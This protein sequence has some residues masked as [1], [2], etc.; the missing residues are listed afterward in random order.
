MAVQASYN[1]VSVHADD[2]DVSARFYTELFDLTDLPAPD[3]GAPTR[4]LRVG[5][6]Q[7]HL[8]GRP[9][10]APRFHHFAI[11]VDD[12]TE[13]YARAER[14]GV[15]DAETY[16]HELIELPDG[17]V[18]LYVRDPAGNLI[19]IDHPDVSTVD[20]RLRAKVHR[21]V[22]DRPQGPDNLRATLFLSPG[23]T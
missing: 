18:Q 2:V 16:G 3:F 17:A 5:D 12:L 1:H 4:W 20:D 8:F 21:M 7:L 19:E 9:T 14:M 11:T 22:E 10:A 6:L 23:A 13:V 15:I